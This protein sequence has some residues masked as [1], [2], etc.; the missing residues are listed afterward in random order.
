MDCGET[1]DVHRVFSG[2]N[3]LEEDFLKAEDLFGGIGS[4]LIASMLS[5]IFLLICSTAWNDRLSMG[6]SGVNASQAF[7]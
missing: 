5:S 4:P 6:L 2:L 1:K 7:I 3:E